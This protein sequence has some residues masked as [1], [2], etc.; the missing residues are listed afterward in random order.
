MYV[1][2]FVSENPSTFVLRDLNL[3]LIVS[4]DSQTW[5]LA[6][7]CSCHLCEFIAG[8]KLVGILWVSVEDWG[9]SP[10]DS[11]CF[12]TSAGTRKHH[13]MGLLHLALNEGP[14]HSPSLFWAWLK[15]QFPRK[16]RKSIWLPACCPSP[17]QVQSLVQKAVC[18]G[19]SLTSC[20]IGY[21][22]NKYVFQSLVVLLSPDAIMPET[23][24][25][26]YSLIISFLYKPSCMGSVAC[27]EGQ[28]LKMISPWW[29][30]VV[31]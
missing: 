29:Y 18:S 24:D 21:I 22:S 31:I 6:S 13:D 1:L 10:T 5:S 3:Q 7:L 16:R 25:S 11:V 27:T 12:S 17:C 20:Q 28:I 30:K 8:L 14:Q 19:T 26:L 23:E 9:S 15:A 4:A 2:Y